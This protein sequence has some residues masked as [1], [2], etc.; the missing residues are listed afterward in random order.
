MNRN[1]MAGEDF[2]N[3][4]TMRDRRA[5]KP[6][7]FVKSDTGEAVAFVPLEVLDWKGTEVAF[8][9]PNV[10]ALFFS[11]AER[12]L[13]KA[14]DLFT[15][16][17][18][19][20]KTVDSYGMVPKSTLS[21]IYDYLEEI[22]TSIVSVYSGAEAITNLAIPDDYTRTVVNSKQIEETWTKKSIE[23]WLSL[24]E[25]I[26][27]I[28]P[29]ILGTPGPQG[30]PHWSDFKR[31]E[32]LRNEIVHPK[33]ESRDIAKVTQTLASRLMHISVFTYIGSGFEVARTIALSDAS[34]VEFPTGF[35]NAQQGVVVVDEFPKM[36]PFNRQRETD[37]T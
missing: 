14:R 33:T 34:H 25:K 2:K 24:T 35:G 20:H 23:R 15:S 30:N 9:A 16:L 8:E 26:S 27:K 6:I 21:S 4:A 12:S 13:H 37:S 31:L 11:S 10:A 29:G 17:C 36:T 1:A 5:R 7:N 3:G 28:L 22:Q 18:D 19:L 32:A